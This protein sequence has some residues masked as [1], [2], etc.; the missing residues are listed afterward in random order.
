[1]EQK[2]NLRAR[3]EATQKEVRKE[4]QSSKRKAKTLFFWLFDMGSCYVAAQAGPDM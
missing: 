4:S 2:D 1:L 3:E